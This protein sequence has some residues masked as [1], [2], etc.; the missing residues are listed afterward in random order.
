MI[1]LQNKIEQAKAKIQAIENVRIERILQEKEKIEFNPYLPFII[2]SDK[3][4][5]YNPYN[6]LYSPNTISNTIFFKNGNV[7]MDHINV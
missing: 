6:P 4:K 1:P 5:Y 7:N 3:T 2:S